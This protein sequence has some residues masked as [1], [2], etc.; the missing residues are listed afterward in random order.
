MRTAVIGYSGAGKS[1]LAKR[2]GERYSCPVLHFDR[3]GWTEGWVQRD[4]EEG[5]ALT[6]RFL[7]END[8]WILE[9]LP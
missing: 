9:R 5:K 8:A 1:T 7:D 4:K 6:A 3:I 2:L